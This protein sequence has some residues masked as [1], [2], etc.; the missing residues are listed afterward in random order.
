MS[1]NATGRHRLCRTLGSCIWGS[2]KCPSLRRAY[3]PGQHGPRMQRR[4]T[5]NFGLQLR[6]KQKLRAY[7]GLREAQFF[8]TYIKASHLKGNTGE[9]LLALLERRLDVAV[10][11]LYLAPTLS[12][13]RQLVLHGHVLVNGKKVDKPNFTLKPGDKV[14]V[15]DK[16]KSKEFVKQTVENH[17]GAPPAYYAFDQGLP[18]GSLVAVPRREDIPLPVQEHMIVELYSR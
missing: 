2:P 7:Y 6:E 16:S 14:T 12:A 5:S 18:G 8:N 3:A 10:Y 1:K 17:A 15:K 13:A 9:N 11:R 4:K